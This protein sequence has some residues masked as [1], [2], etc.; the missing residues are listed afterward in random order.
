M[1]SVG[2]SLNLGL[3]GSASRITAMFRL[4]GLA[5]NAKIPPDVARVAT[6]LRDREVA[7]FSNVVASARQYDAE[8]N[9]YYRRNRRPEW[10][11]VAPGQSVLDPV[12][13][14]LQYLRAAPVVRNSQ[15]W[16]DMP[17]ELYLANRYAGADDATRSILQGLGFVE[18]ANLGADAYSEDPNKLL[19]VAD[20]QAQVV[21]LEGFGIRKAAPAII[22]GIVALV[23]V[24]AVGATVYAYVSTQPER[25]AIAATEAANVRLHRQAMIMAESDQRML[26]YC[27][28]HARANGLPVSGC[29]DVRARMNEWPQQLDPMRTSCGALSC[30]PWMLGLGGVGA[31]LG[32]SWMSRR[33]A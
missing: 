32:Y 21:D 13:Y 33:R 18:A 17:A 11:E 7:S 25:D 26:N 14:Q 19:E 8:V 2:D 31:L 29:D 23:A 28:E 1:T 3:F 22:W 4:Q 12:Y 20:L 24:A 10:P 27:L 16:F 15:V 9:E 5:A 6:E 30:W